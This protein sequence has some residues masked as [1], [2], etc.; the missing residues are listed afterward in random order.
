MTLE[1][2]LYTVSLLKR[3]Y[4]LSVD[5]YN[6]KT[7]VCS[8]F[9]KKIFLSLICRHNV[10]TPVSGEKEAHAAVARYR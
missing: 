10:K 4:H 2:A 1:P 7:V 9:V 6:V 8:L 3:F 5:I